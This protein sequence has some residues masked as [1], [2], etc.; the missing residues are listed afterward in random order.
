MLDQLSK[1]RYW[2]QKAIPDTLP[3]REDFEEQMEVRENRR[4]L[5]QVMNAAID[6]VTQE[7]DEQQPVAKSPVLEKKYDQERQ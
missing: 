5:E 7:D 2:T 6:A 4:E 1:L 3:E